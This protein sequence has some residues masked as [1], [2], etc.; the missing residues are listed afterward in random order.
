MS[1][2]LFQ[3]T[4]F[5]FQLWKCLC[6]DSCKFMAWEWDYIFLSNITTTGFSRHGFQ[7]AGIGNGKDST[8]VFSSSSNFC[9]SL[10]TYSIWLGKRKYTCLKSIFIF[11]KNGLRVPAFQDLNVHKRYFYFLIR[12]L[13]NS[14]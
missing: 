13:E 1:F 7:Q 2:I 9:L 3:I 5:G 6:S 12:I 8:W 4:E 10:H 11:T 14:G